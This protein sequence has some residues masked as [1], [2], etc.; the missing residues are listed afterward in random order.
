MKYFFTVSG[1]SNSATCTWN[2]QFL[3]SDVLYKRGNLKSF[4]KFT[5]NHK[6][7]SSGGV[8]SELVLKNFAKFTDKHLCSSLILNEVVGWKPETARSSQCT[9]SV[10]KVFLKRSLVFQNQPFIDPLQN[11]CSW[12]IHKFHRKKSV[13][14]SLFN[15]VAVLRICDFIKE[16]SGTGAFLWILWIIQEHLFCK[17]ST[18]G[19]FWNTSAGVSV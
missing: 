19:W 16:D 12:I 5:D 1:G 14:E 6:K 8:L 9:C 7:Q 13:L 2:K 3:L 18:N 15:K 11:R 17:A 4:S 10:K